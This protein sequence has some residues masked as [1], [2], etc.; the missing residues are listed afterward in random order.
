MRIAFLCNRATVVILSL[1]FFWCNAFAQ[2]KFE[3]VIETKN[4][5]IDEYGTLQQ[6]T[7][8]M[9]VK[10][11]MVMIRNS[12]L[13]STPAS[14][15]I[16]RGDKNVVWMLDEESKSYFEIRQDDKPKQVYSPSGKNN[17]GPAVRK[18]GKRK[19]V[20]G[21]ACDQIIIKDDNVMTELW[22]TKALGNLFGTISKILG[23]EGINQGW[24][25]KVMRM[26]YYPL[27]ASTKVEG[28]VMES[29]EATNIEKRS[30]TQELFELPEGFKKQSSDEILK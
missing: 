8:T 13:G 10:Q 2:P 28:K 11:D 25:N 30:L 22:A 26:G 6:F 3:G 17:K 29:Q 19:Q 12:P 18:T 1:V 20:A 27:I 5:T 16:Y 14:V 9:Y 15:M 23:G 7:M 24:E 4:T 21:F